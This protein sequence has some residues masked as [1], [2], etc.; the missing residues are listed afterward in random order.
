MAD[1]IEISQAGGDAKEES[2]LM[3]FLMT[4]FQFPKNSHVRHP[5][6]FQ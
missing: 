5:G 2:A 1:A 6:I 4:N 3:K